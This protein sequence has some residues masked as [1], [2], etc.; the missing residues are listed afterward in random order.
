MLQVWPYKGK[1]KKDK[2]GYKK[3][4]E[5]KSRKSDMQIRVP[6]RENSGSGG[7]GVITDTG[8]QGYFPK[9]KLLCF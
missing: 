5:E 6:E 4:I 1:K 8:L 9:L 7:D 2:R 3:T